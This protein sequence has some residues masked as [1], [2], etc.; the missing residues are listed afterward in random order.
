MQLLAPFLTS[1]FAARS[2]P[3]QPTASWSFVLLQFVALNFAAA[4]QQVGRARLHHFK[5][6]SQL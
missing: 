6:A 3:R 2:W 5:D 1:S 4:S